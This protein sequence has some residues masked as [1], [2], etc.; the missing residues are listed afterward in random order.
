MRLRGAEVKG[1][2]RYI[3]LS[4]THPILKSHIAAVGG[5]KA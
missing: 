2:H 4:D 5:E 1:G 3:I